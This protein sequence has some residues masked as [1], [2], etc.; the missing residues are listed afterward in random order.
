MVDRARVI[1]AVDSSG[2]MLAVLDAKAE[3]NGWANVSTMTVPGRPA[4]PYDLVVCSSVCG[5]LEDYPA[6]VVELVS[7]LRPGGLFVQWDWEAD[8]GAS[9][10][11]GLARSTIETALS[12]A[13]L[14][15]VTV[16]VGFT[17]DYEGEKMAPL[18][19]SGRTPVG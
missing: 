12:G 10:G 18:M 17:Q 2:A 9:E 7:H 15:S 5:F 3:A 13:G 11:D 4:T 6:M 16:G 8:E 1:D 14:E 19:G